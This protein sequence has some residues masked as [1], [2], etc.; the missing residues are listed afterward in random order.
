MFSKSF[1]TLILVHFTA[2]L[3]AQT[4]VIG[5]KE[6][7]FA[8]AEVDEQSV[9][10]DANQKYL[11]GDYT[12]A[13]E[14]L[15]KYIYDHEDND[16]A[17]FVMARVYLAQKEYNN[18][19]IS[20]QKAIKADPANKW[21]YHLQGDI[22]EVTGRSTD[23]IGVYERLV[24][25]TA[26]DESNYEKLS[27]LYTLA[28]KPEQALGALDRWQQMRGITE[29]IAEKR[30]LIALGMKNDQAAIKAL[31]DLSDAYPKRT[32]YMHKLARY[33]RETNRQKEASIQYQRILTINPDD[34]EARIGTVN[35][36]TTTGSE[37][38]FLADLRPLL[39]DPTI[40]ID[41]KIGKLMP[42]L[43]KMETEKDS[44][45]RAQMQNAASALTETHPNEAK[46]WSFAG[47][48]H[49]LLNDNAQALT[50]YQKCI[51]LQPEVFSVWQNTY[52]ILRGQENYA[53]LAK[54]AEKGMDAFPNQPLSYYFYGLAANQLNKPN[55]AMPQL[56][57]A[58]LMSGNNLGLKMD[59]QS[60]V[61]LAHIKVNKAD[62]AIELL[63]ATF[64]KGGNKH[65]FIME[66]LG[67]AYAAKGNQPKA[68]ELWKAAEKIQS[69]SRLLKK[70]GL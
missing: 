59:I 14:M 44:L 61:G 24:T 32:E 15:E 40:A 52:E 48:V 50:K 66:Y 13:Q 1:Y 69:S 27:Y 7:R 34:P 64:A 39:A 33:Y 41:S 8:E 20:I 56:Q 35:K 26:S 6:Q 68:V 47:D 55:D 38:D 43:K 54:I 51:A 10:I 19:L 60:E 2:M 9:F 37:Q 53:E 29:E 25:Q 21:Y 22:Y 67:D 62:K 5:A 31:Q 18:A 65:P 12:K 3:M 49:Y 58:M 63:E 46:A 45:K 16:G 30:H 11:L 57:Q 70:V 4:N 42:I 23:A 36:S 28:G 17:H